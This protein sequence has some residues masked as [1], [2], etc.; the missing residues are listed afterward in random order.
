MVRAAPGNGLNIENIASLNMKIVSYLKETQEQLAVL[1]DDVLYD[2]E[3]IHPDLPNTM[4]MFLNY[5]DELFPIIQ[6]GE[7]AIREGH[8]GRI[9]A[10]PVGRVPLL[11]P[12]PFP[13]SSR[14]AYAFRPHFARARRTRKGPAIPGFVKS[15]IFYFTNQHI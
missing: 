12:F 5:W 8:I 2:M 10:V 3:L 13:P 11:A 4:S 14:V 6:A 7:L 1:V 15:H 9:K